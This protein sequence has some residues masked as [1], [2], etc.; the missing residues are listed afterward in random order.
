MDQRQ[1]VTKRSEPHPIH[2]WDQYQSV[3]FITPPRAL[4]LHCLSRWKQTD[5]AQFSFKRRPA[6]VSR[7]SGL[8]VSRTSRKSC[9]QISIKIGQ[10]EEKNKAN[11][12]FF[13][14]SN[15]LMDLFEWNHMS[16]TTV[17]HCV[18]FLEQRSNITNLE[19]FESFVE[20]CTLLPCD[21]FLSPL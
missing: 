7:S 1:R 14:L 20:V 21:Y 8:F 16:P 4:S 2:F 18:Y 13:F 11:I 10:E 3:F 15:E 9:R 17:H 19:D 5:G 12:S 6:R